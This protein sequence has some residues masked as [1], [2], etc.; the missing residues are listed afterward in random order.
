MATQVNARRLSAIVIFPY[1]EIQFKQLVLSYCN[2]M[3]G[4]LC[5]L[6]IEELRKIAIIQRNVNG[7]NVYE[8]HVVTSSEYSMETFEKIRDIV[9]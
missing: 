9:Y 5:E 3:N 1:D 7:C 8:L 4:S 6:Q 2:R